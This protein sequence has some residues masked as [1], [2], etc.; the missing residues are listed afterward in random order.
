[1]KGWNDNTEQ[2][3]EWMKEILLLIIFYS[4]ATFQVEETLHVCLKALENKIAYILQFY[5]K[6]SIINESHARFMIACSMSSQ[7]QQPNFLIN[8]NT[9]SKMVSIRIVWPSKMWTLFSKIV[10][11][12]RARLIKK[13]PCQ[14]SIVLC[15]VVA[16]RS[17][18]RTR[19]VRRKKTGK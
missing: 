16:L 14:G 3:F 10:A 4:S 7:N 19:N 17:V 13:N 12:G 15:G 18:V 8:W 1:M 5:S 9:H 2:I 6:S 11:I